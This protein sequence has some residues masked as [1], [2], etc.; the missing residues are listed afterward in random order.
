MILSFVIMGLMIRYYRQNRYHTYLF[1]IFG[2]LFFVLQGIIAR[3]FLPQEESGE[4]P[5]EIGF[6]EFLKIAVPI[7][8]VMITLTGAFFFLVLFFQSFES[9]RV[10]TRTNLYLTLLFTVLTAGLLVSTLQLAVSFPQVE[11]KTDEEVFESNTG[12]WIIFPTLLFI[13]FMVGCGFFTIAM[14]IRVFLKLHRRIQAT[15]DPL[16]KGKLKKMRY[17]II[18]L[19]WAEMVEMWTGGVMAVLAFG[20][21]VYLYSSSGTFFLPAKTLQKFLIIS[22]EGMPLYSYSFQPDESESIPF[23][24]QDVLF[25][26]ALRAISTLFSEFTG[27]MDQTLKEVTLESVIV[28]ANQIVDRRFL[29]VLLVEQSTR[30]FREAFDNATEQ[31]DHFISQNKPHPHKTLTIPQIQAMDQVIENNFGGGLQRNYETQK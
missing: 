2:T 3:L 10:L 17:A 31:L 13:I 20:Y 5:A 30:F 23:D 22:T 25:S 7:G 12:G 14:V 28:M 9:S 11:G 6:A 19:L 27:K 21:F 4:E 16:I 8:L 26:G 29:V 15:T 18:A 24:S 1:L